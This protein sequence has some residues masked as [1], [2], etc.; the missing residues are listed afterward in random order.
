MKYIINKI[1]SDT[2]KTPEG[3]FSRKSLTMLVSFIMAII[4]GIYISISDYI[5]N[6]EINKYTIEVFYG[7]LLLSGGTSVMTIWEKFKNKSG[8]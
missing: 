7:F 3:K 5:L 2:L 4:L 8:E 6:K 1:I